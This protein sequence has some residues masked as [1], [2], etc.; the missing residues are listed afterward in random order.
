MFTISISI[1]SCSAL[2]LL[3]ILFHNRIECSRGNA[4]IIC[5]L[6]QQLLL[7]LSPNVASLYQQH[8]LAASNIDTV[9][10][11]LSSLHHHMFYNS[12]Y[13][14]LYAASTSARSG[15]KKYTHT[16]Y[17][18][19]D[20]YNSTASYSLHRINFYTW[21]NVDCSFYCSSLPTICW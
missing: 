2:R 8:F 11:S 16:L 4:S 21:E 12:I 1:A 19:N 17:S 14:T 6:Y 9:F 10:S 20:R 15:S 13:P 3:S 18:L 5:V 7:L